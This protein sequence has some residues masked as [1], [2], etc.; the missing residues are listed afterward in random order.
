MPPRIS[1]ILETSLYVE[2]LERSQA[3][4]QQ[5]FGFDVFIADGRMVALGAPASGVVLLFARGKSAR[6]SETPGGVIPPH[7]AHGQQHLC[8]GIAMDALDAWSDHLARLD[9]A[10]ESRVTW[11]RGGVSLYFRD[12]DGHSLEVATPGLWPNF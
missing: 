11:P 9:I 1:H 10:V 2:D 7:D 6:P 12:P 4:Y 3:F 8:F 5:V